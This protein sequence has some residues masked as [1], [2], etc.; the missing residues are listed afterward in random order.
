MELAG[1]RGA[2]KAM[3][4]SGLTPGRFRRPEAYEPL[5]ARLAEAKFRLEGA[6]ATGHS[7]FAWSGAVPRWMRPKLD[8][9]ALRELEP[10]PGSAAVVAAKTGRLG[11]R[12]SDHDFVTCQVRL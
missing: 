7:T 6:N 11:R 5:F 8:W 4:L 10:V 9:I 2:I 3:L 12:I 1:L